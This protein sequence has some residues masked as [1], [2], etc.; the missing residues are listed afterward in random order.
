ML[1]ATQVIQNNLI[2]LANPIKW[3]VTIKINYKKKCNIHVHNVIKAC[4][5]THTYNIIYFVKNIP[6]IYYDIL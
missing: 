3:C 4:L 6:L 1:W 5:T 2:L